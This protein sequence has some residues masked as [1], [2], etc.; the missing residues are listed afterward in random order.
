MKRSVPVVIL[1]IALLVGACVAGPSGSSGP[2]A[3]PVGSGMIGA[4]LVA[5]ITDEGGLMSPVDALMQG[6][7][8]ALY[9]DGR[10]FEPVALPTVYPGPFLPSIHQFKV[11]P[12]GIQ[13]V[14][15][16]ARTDGLAGHDQAYPA[17]N[18]A[19]APDT[20]ITV[21]V[22]GHPVT[23]RFAALGAGATASDPIEQAARTGA[24]DYVTKLRGNTAFFGSADVGSEQQYLPDVV[25]IV[26]VHGDPSA[27]VQPSEMVHAPLAW[28]LATPLGEFGV[29]VQAGSAAAARCGVVSGTDLQVLWPLFEQASQI[30]GFSSGGTTWR[31]TLR[32][33]LPGEPG[34]CSLVQP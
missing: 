20:V 28:P 4:G 26:A 17:T 27:G 23:S 12:A 18:V 1:F 13:R 24:Q 34:S 16:L 8:V 30:T 3:S 10:L 29:G 22:D 31:L 33:L 2:T 21:A 5:S 6:P 9:A 32:L 19:D 14:L 15:D 11:T 25:Q 7:D